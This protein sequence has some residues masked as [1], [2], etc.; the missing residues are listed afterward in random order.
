VRATVKPA[1]LD[2]AFDTDKAWHGG[3]PIGALRAYQAYHPDA[4]IYTVTYRGR[5]VWMT[6][7]QRAI[8]S[9]AQKYWQRGKRDTLE[10][11]A[12]VVRCSRAT[13]SRFL[14]RLDLWRFIDLV[15]LRGRNGGTYILTRTDPYNEKPQ[16]WT[17]EKRNRIRATLAEIVRRK[18][19]A[20]LSPLLADYRRR[21]GP[22]PALPPYWQT[23]EQLTYL[24][25]S[26]GATYRR[27]M[28]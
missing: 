20:A 14:R 19:Y 7:K 17:M 16:R 9:E 26:T 27:Y 25:G 6:S 10:R 28:S 15:T 13:V 2:H 5:T 1:S 21:R 8:W 24:T 22:L 4:A 23:A 18:S 11:I 3:G 12:S